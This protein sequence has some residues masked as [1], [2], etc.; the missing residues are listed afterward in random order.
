MRRVLNVIIDVLIVALFAISLLVVALALTSRSTGI[1]NIAGYTLFSVQTDSMEPTIM[2]G[3]LMISQIGDSDDVYEVGD[4]VT[5]QMFVDRT[6]ILNSHR[7]VDIE[8]VNGVTYYMTKGDNAIGQDATELSAGDIVAKWSG[9]KLSGM[10]TV[11]DFLQTQKGFF[12]C[13]LL[14]LIVFF[15]VMLYGFIKN[16]IAYN[17]DKAMEAAAGTV[18]ELTEEQK[19]KA[20]EEYLAGQKAQNSADTDGNED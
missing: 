20:I 13:V 10:G 19:R 3:D 1:P 14:P 11:M 4:V 6:R 5:F 18:Q 17:R 16:L 9:K 7:I 2:T 12:L 15:L 8:E